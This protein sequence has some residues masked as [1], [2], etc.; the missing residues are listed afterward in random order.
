MSQI[1]WLEPPKCL[2]GMLSTR[3]KQLLVRISQL[4]KLF[5]SGNILVVYTLKDL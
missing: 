3:P 1:T 4:H 5:I 2:S